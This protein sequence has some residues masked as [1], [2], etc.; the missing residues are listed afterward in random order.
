LWYM[1]MYLVLSPFTYL[2]GPPYK[3]CIKLM[4]LYYL[5]LPSKLSS[6]AYAR[7]SCVLFSFNP[8][9]FSWTYQMANS[10]AVAIKR[11]N[12]IPFWIGNISDMFACLLFT[13]C[14]I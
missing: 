9:W 10:E 12:V 8:S 5:S 4:C 1:N 7:S 3:Q 6:S 14:F 13:V 11:L 2:N